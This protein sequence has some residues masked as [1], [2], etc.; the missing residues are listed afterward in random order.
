MGFVTL[1]I[2]IMMLR[3]RLFKAFTLF[4]TQAWEQTLTPSGLMNTPTL[5]DTRQTQ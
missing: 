3:I 1:E 4:A 2:I 5:T